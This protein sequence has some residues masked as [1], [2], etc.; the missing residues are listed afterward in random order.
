MKGLGMQ[1]SQ[2]SVKGFA[3]TFFIEGDNASILVDTGL[4]GGEKAILGEYQRRNTPLKLIVITHGHFD[5]IGS[6]AALKRET[7]APIAIGAADA[8][9]LRTGI[10]PMD[11][12]V[13][14]IARIMPFFMRSST[15]EP[16]EPDIVVEEDRSL[17]EFGID[18]RILVTP[19]HTH[20]SISVMLD[21]GEA[22][23]GDLIMGGFFG[24]IRRRRPNLPPFE[25]GRSTIKDSTRHV[26]EQN[27]SVIYP[28]HGGPF[29]PKDVLR[30][31]DSL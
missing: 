21:S 14:V 23:V 30:W 5:H 26:L 19:G 20:G 18:G 11:K 7:G 3:N 24:K 29:D 6:A 17:Q 13:G 8:Q 16:V 1:I 22:F 4:P 2:V 12:P 10:S 28:A 27:P 9:A 15:A 25:I 31:A